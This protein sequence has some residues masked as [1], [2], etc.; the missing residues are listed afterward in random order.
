MAK[1]NPLL[2]NRYLRD[3]YV[4]MAK[5]RMIEEAAG[6]KKIRGRSSGTR[7]QEACVATVLLAL[8]AGDLLA[9]AWPSAGTRYLLGARLKE[10]LAQRKAGEDFLSVIGSVTRAKL[11]PQIEDGMARVQAAM[12][13]AMALRIQGSGRF[14]A[15]FVQPGEIG[16]AAWRDLLKVAG[17]T[18]APL[19]VVVLP[20]FDRKAAGKAGRLSA[21]SMGWGI[22]GIPVEASDAIALSRVVQESTGRLR[23][24]GGPVLMECLR[25]PSG[26]RE[27][28]TRRRSKATDPV[29]NFRKTLLDRVIFRASWAERME[30]S[31]QAQIDH[32]R[33][34]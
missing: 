6:A 3:L 28:G 31:F 26:I 11:L 1:E 21:R 27:P 10:V 2:P 4:A 15:V 12:G 7:G 17:E 9:E 18:E 29:A 14:A 8:E 34:R 25:L 22:P 5:F 33:A 23:G 32:R 24:G 19:L 30:T 13:A 20:A 16:G